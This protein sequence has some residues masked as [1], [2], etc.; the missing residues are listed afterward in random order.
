MIGTWNIRGL[1]DPKKQ[2]EVIALIGK[3]KL[4]ALGINETWVK[5]ENKDIKC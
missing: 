1:N 4:E 5:W 2:L 3:Y